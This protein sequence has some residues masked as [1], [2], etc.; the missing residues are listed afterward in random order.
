MTARP[1]RSAYTLLEVLLALGIATL[2]LAGLYVSMEVQL[3]LADAGRNR[4]DEAALARSLLNRIA[5]DVAPALTPI[6][7]STSAS[8][9]S[10]AAP[11]TTDTTGSSATS[12]TT[13][14][15]LNA[16]TPFN[17]GVNGDLDR[18]TMFISRAPTISRGTAD[19]DAA[20]NGVPPDVRRVTYWRASDLGLARQE[21][22]RVTAE[23][24][25]SALPPDVPD[26]ASFVISAEVDSIEFKYFDGAAWQD[27]WDGAAISADG[28]TPIG[29]PRAVK[30]VIGIRSPSSGRVTTYSHVM[31]IQTANG[32]PAAPT[33]ETEQ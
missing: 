1:H 26:E 20:P 14:T 24:E 18:L 3:G 22:S 11:T 33:T 9:S 2:L 25:N 19:A 17:C 15:N 16:V 28:V 7:G 31:A 27:T 23:G 8:S 12:T 4:V 10:G 32:Q 29:P 30:V 6:R 21:I 13:T 5:A